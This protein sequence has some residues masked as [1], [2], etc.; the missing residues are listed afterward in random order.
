MLAD[1][2]NADKEDAW[3]LETHSFVKTREDFEKFPWEIA[4][5]LDFSSF[6]KVKELLPEGMKVIAVSGKIFTLTWMLMGFNHFA[7]SLIMDE[8]L[9]AD[10]FRKVAEIQFK[11]LTRI[12]ELP[13]VDA[14]WVVD[15]LAFGTGPMISPQAYRDHVFPWYREM[16]DRCHRNNRIFFMHSDGDLWQLMEDIIDVGVDVLQP[17]DPS[18]MDIVKVKHVYG[19]RLCL[20]GNV[21]NELLRSGTTAEVE[22]RVKALIRDLAPGGGYCVGAGNSVPDW[23]KFENFMAMR[24]AALKYGS[25]PI[26]I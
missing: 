12:F 14:V 26:A 22:E 6:Y 13:Y 7:L 5:E 21:A 25:Y 10:V 4:G 1:S 16:A 15:D 9:V 2:P 11:G 3:N 20:V 23:A 19:D 18:C 24:N 8:K 17:I